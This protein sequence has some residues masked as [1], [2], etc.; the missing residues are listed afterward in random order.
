MSGYLKGKSVI[1]LGGA[2]GIGRAT[3]EASVREG[4]AVVIADR[5]VVAAGRLATEIGER[6]LAFELDVSNAEMVD[7]G[8]SFTVA[9][10]GRLDALVNCAAR[11]EPFRSLLDASEEDFAGIVD[12]NL[13]G[14]WL[15]MRAA[16]RQFQRQGGG[17]AIINISSAAGLKGSPAMAIY[18]ASKHAV[19]GLT[20]SAAL[21]FA[22]TG[23]R[24]NAVCP[25]V[26]D[27]PMMQGVASD[28]RARK[29]FEA[30]QPNGRFGRAEEVGETCAWLI[31][32]RASL[33]TGAILGVDGGL[34]A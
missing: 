6:A 17:G 24:I 28:P 29:A 33:I 25:G 15:A 22:K 3:V 20:R 23:P 27:T 8:I 34:T 14:T 21:E 5:D 4:A 30:A 32:D 10:F 19:I 9:A 26:I 11:P 2:S 18:S 31:S 1:V 12:I 13:R 7:A 16:I